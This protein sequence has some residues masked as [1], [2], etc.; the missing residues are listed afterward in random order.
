M[1]IN[2]QFLNKESIFCTSTKYYW[3]ILIYIIIHD[4]LQKTHTIVNIR[5]SFIKDNKKT[6]LIHY[7]AY[8]LI[9]KKM[10]KNIYIYINTLCMS[11][12]Y[13][14]YLL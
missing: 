9:V 3:D 4:I 7:K 1:K 6:I 12:Y 2:I 5:L 8:K 10:Y 13:L 11:Y 14:A